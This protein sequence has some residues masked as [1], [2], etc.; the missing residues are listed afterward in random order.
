MTAALGGSCQ[1]VEPAMW[2]LFEWTAPLDAGAQGAREVRC[3]FDQMSFRVVEVNRSLPPG[4]VFGSVKEGDPAG[5]H[6]PIS[7][8][9]VVN[10][11]RHRPLMGA[12]GRAT[13]LPLTGHLGHS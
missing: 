7:A 6:L 5:G 11:D 1:I 2:F 9:Y 4:A 13:D 12:G 8:I 3:E 10:Q